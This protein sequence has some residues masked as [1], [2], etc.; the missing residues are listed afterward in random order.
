[1]R[2][3]TSPLMIVLLLWATGLAAA[4]QF[5][6]IATVFDL[7]EGVW[8]GV[9][10]AMLG[11]M[12]S[13]VGFAGIALGAAAGL[14][15]QGAGY[16]RVLVAA[17]GAGAVLS[18]AQALLPPLPVMLA[19]RLAEG[20][21]HLAIVVAAPTLIAQIAPP[22]RQGL[23]MTLW[24]SFFAVSFA[25]TAWAG[26]PLAL[27][28]GLAALILAHAALMA[29]LAVL[30]A[31]ALPPDPPGRAAWPGLRDLAAQHAAIYA[32]SRQAA[33]AMGFFCY[34]VLYVAILTLLPPLVAPW[35][36]PVATAL[37]LL[38]IA[39]S[40]TLGVWALRHMTAVA[41]VQAGFAAGLAGGVVMA[42][43]WDV[44]A[45]RLAGAGVLAAAMGVVQGASFAAIPQLNPGAEGRARAAGA[46]AQL[47]N[48]GTT[49]GTPLMAAL[50]AGLGPAPG[51]AAMVLPFCI[52]GI[53]LHRVQARRR[54]VSG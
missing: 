45:L 44:M 17:L 12:V 4:G 10:P 1:M 47:G 27:A 6:K 23:A 48:V 25:V 32:S 26:R 40:L 35:Q 7:A 18:A 54:A 21:S 19:L 43:G 14:V 16:R 53:A 41:L 52:A 37:P 30:V 5:G 8:P 15:L 28:Q 9:S 38:S 2:A 11:L 42:L 36:G 20:V 13:C 46:I 51:I 24:S 22:E 33:P 49:A 34:T 31:R 39:V 50:V 29:V 3:P